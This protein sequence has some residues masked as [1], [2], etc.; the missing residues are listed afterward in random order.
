MRIED[1]NKFNRILVG[2]IIARVWRTALPAELERSLLPG[3]IYMYLFLPI[4]LTRLGSQLHKNSASRQVIISVWLH[5]DYSCNLTP[6]VLWYWRLW[7]MLYI[8]ITI[9]KVKF[10]WSWNYS[11]HTVI[12][13]VSSWKYFDGLSGVAKLSRGLYLR[14]VTQE[15]VGY[16]YLMY[17]KTNLTNS[18]KRTQSLLEC[19]LRL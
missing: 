3:F 18:V 13:C 1:Q 12:Q 8:S 16:C 11:F 10:I 2:R 6:N 15:L 17:D 4:R 14:W 7:S 9:V 19:D 5:K